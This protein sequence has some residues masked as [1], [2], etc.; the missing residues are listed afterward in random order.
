[1]ETSTNIDQITLQAITCGSYN[2]AYR[3]HRNR[4]IF[5]YNGHRL[6]ILYSIAAHSLQEEPVYLHESSQD[7]ARWM[8]RFNEPDNYTVYRP[9]RTINFVQYRYTCMMYNALPHMFVT[10]ND[11]LSCN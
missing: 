10:N 1:M 7:G 5:R 6:P 11:L 9:Q 4:F 2:C 8:N 3:S